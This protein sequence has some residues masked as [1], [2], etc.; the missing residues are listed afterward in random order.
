MFLILLYTG[1]ADLKNQTQDIRKLLATRDGNYAAACALD[2][3]KPPAF[4][5]TFAL[6]DF[7]GHEAATTAWPYF[8]SRVSREAL[9][10]GKPTPVESCWNGVVAMDAKPFY[11]TPRLTFRGV[12]DSLAKLH[13]EGSECCLIHTDNPLSREQGVWVNP[14][15]RVGY[16]ERAYREV[17][18]EGLSTWMS[19]FSIA[20]GLWTNRLSRWST[21]PL[22]KEWVIR[23]RIEQWKEK[24]PNNH[25][26]GSSCLINEM[27]ILTS[28]GWAHV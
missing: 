10:H 21:S 11:Q 19:V 7:K 4:Y 27:Q 28:Y 14:N 18:P 20:R 15:V 23:R 8:R 9:K 26:T 25:E 6:R 22:L 3:S 17:N 12:P 1:F 16:N 2:F 13:V 5:D 24:H